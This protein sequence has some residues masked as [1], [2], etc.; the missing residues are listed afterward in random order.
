AGE[1]TV[2]PDLFSQAL[3]SASAGCEAVDRVM[4]GELAAAFCGVRPPGHHANRFRALGFCVFNNVA[5]AAE[6]AR[7]RYGVK[8]VLVV[9]W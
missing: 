6:Y 2:T 3:L 8:T 5:V 7:E 4:N 1:T 9:D